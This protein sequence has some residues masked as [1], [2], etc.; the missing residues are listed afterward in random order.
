M[1]A[2]AQWPDFFIEVDTLAG[3]PRLQDQA[4]EDALAAQYPPQTAIQPG[5]FDRR[6]EELRWMG[7]VLREFRAP[8]WQLQS[9]DLQSAWYE[10]LVRSRD[11]VQRAALAEGAMEPTAQAT[12]ASPGQVEPSPRPDSEPPGSAQGSV[13]N[14]EEGGMSADEIPP[15]EPPVMP[16]NLPEPGTHTS[17]SVRQLLGY[18][19]LGS[20]TQDGL[21]RLITAL[22]SRGPDSSE[23]IPADHLYA[24]IMQLG[25]KPTPPNSHD[26]KPWHLSYADFCNAYGFGD[27][28]P[29]M[30]A[31]KFIAHGRTQKL[32]SRLDR[33]LERTK[34]ENIFP[35][36]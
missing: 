18:L 13:E 19:C 14:D 28:M 25:V 4:D 11:E 3:L 5:K 21:A 7:H 15:L 22:C 8:H 26:G 27:E 17:I 32:L 29:G 34:L 10:Y 30:S 35:K 24:A 6:S 33:R 23:E 36:P 31:E 16:Q 20:S 2:G 1:P 12:D 9:Y